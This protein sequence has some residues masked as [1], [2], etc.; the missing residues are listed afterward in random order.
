MPG[1]AAG[2]CGSEFYFHIESG[3][4]L[5]FQTININE[6][7]HLPIL[8]YLGLCHIICLEF[9][10]I[11]IIKP[12][13]LD[14]CRH[15]KNTFG[16]NQ[17]SSHRLESSVCS[18]FLPLFSF[19]LVLVYS[20]IYDPLSPNPHIFSFLPLALS[21]IY[22]YINLHLL[23]LIK[24]RPSPSPLNTLIHLKPSQVAAPIIPFHTIMFF[25]L[26]RHIY[27]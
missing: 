1:E 3:H 22:I 15:T 13:K 19:S 8:F 11:S 27:T 23:A 16:P 6:S 20:R 25:L 14:F 7:L 10:G 2:A 18:A 17:L 4:H 12:F 9:T 5:C 26:E 24:T 21:H